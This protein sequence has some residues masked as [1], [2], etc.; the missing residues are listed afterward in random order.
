MIA[1]ALDEYGKVAAAWLLNE[2]CNYIEG[3]KKITFKDN[4][5]L[6]TVALGK[7]LGNPQML[8]MVQSGA[9]KAT[10]DPK[11]SSC[12]GVTKEL[13]EYGYNH[14]K[15]WSDQIRHLQKNND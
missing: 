10:S 9:Q 15:N 1:S 12:D 2:R 4:V 11:Y 7:D 3:D 14:S 5:A 6:I 13:F 8:Y